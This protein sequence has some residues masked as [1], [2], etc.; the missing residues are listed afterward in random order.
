MV[1]QALEKSIE[2]ELKSTPELYINGDGTAL[3]I[4]IRNLID[5]AIRYSPENTIIMVI[6]SS[7]QDRIVLKIID[8]GPGIPQELKSRV[9]ERFYRIL[10]NKSPGSGLG[11]AIVQQIAELHHAHIHLETPESGIGLEVQI[12]FPGVHE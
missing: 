5:N 4:L 8:Q 10:G 11:L 1:P 2:L 12:W 9:F 7:I 6:I 3:D